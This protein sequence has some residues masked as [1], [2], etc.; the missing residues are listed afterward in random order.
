MKMKIIGILVFILTIIIAIFPVIGIKSLESDKENGFN[1][2]HSPSTLG[3]ISVNITK[4]TKAL[5]ILNKAIISFPWPVVIGPIT[6]EVKAEDDEIGINRVE[7]YISNKLVS[8]DTEEPYFWKWSTLTFGGR[9][10]KVVAYNNLG[11]NASAG[12][13]VWTLF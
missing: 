12:I 2:N 11:N 7:I 1:S 10:I 9:V 3:N 13:W 5:Y 4:P 6:I 8:N